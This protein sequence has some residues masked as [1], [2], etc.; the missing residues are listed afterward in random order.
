MMDNH[1]IILSCGWNCEKYVR[2]HIESVQGQTYKNYTHILIDDAST[3]HTHRNI[4]KYA[5]GTRVKIH[6][7]KENIKWIRNALSYLSGKDD[8]IVVLLDLDDFLLNKNALSIV[9]KAYNDTNCWITSSQFIYQSNKVSSSWIPEYSK[10]VIE[11]KLFREHAWSFT[12]LRTFK[13][14]LWNRLDKNDL[15]GKDGKYARCTY[16]QFLCLPML[17]MATPDHYFHIRQPL[18]AYNDRNPMNVHRTNHNEQLENERFVRSKKK[19]D[20]LYK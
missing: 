7:N 12:H 10:K 5:K 20:T 8:D 1:Y 14:F 18:Y 2:E 15:K 6:R 9:N 4:L 3:D 17:E 13:Y 11:N 19:Y 16:D